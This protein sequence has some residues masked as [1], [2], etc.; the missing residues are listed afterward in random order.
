M[1]KKQNRFDDNRISSNVIEYGKEIFEH[2]KGKWRSDYFKNENKIVLELACGR[3]EYSTGLG[4]IYKDKNFIGVDIKGDRIWVGS[5]KARLDGLVNVAFL[6]AQIDHLEAFFESGEINE[7]WIIFPDPRPKGRDKRRRLTSPK[8]LEIYKKLINLGGV[9]HLK[10]DSTALF[11]YTLGL[12]EN[13]ED[14]Q[15][16]NYSWDLYNSN[17]TK[18]HHDIKTKYEHQFSGQ[19]HEIK[20]LRFRFKD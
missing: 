15:D 7:I 6:R 5:K 12:L 14:V 16:L 2:I 9:I 18:G 19:G 10:T 3:G 8:F 13:R 11:D 1:R 20:Y 4:A 17:F